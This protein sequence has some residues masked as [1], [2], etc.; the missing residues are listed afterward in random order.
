[1]IQC[2]PGEFHQLAIEH[3]FEVMD[4]PFGLEQRVAAQGLGLVE[5]LCKAQAIA[6]PVIVGAALMG[7]WAPGLLGFPI[8]MRGV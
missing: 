6:F 5:D 2:G 1:M 4:L 7:M 3:G 8:F